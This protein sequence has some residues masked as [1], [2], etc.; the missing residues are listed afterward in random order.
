MRTFYLLMKQS[1]IVQALIT[2]IIVSTIS[3]LYVVGRPVPPDLMTIA[4]LILGFYFG[5]KTQQKVERN[6]IDYE[7]RINNY[8]DR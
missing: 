3:Y 2:L 4:V 5:S 8:S 7:N 1:I 6:V